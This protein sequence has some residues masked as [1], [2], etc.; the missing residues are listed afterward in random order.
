MAG[1][2]HQGELTQADMNDMLGYEND[3]G[4][5]DAYRT[6]DN[7]PQKSP[8][9]YA[10]EQPPNSSHTPVARQAS[11]ESM[12]ARMS[13]ASPA[14]MGFAY[15]TMKGAGGANAARRKT[16]IAGNKSRTSIKTFGGDRASDPPHPPPIYFVFVLV[17]SR[18]LVEC[19]ESPSTTLEVG[20]PQCLF[21]VR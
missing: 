12:A 7:T 21:S 15:M 6:M 10:N 4:V 1:K 8:T 19:A 14:A 5:D 16:L 20:A 11:T 3:V 13:H 9:K 18:T 17:S 2:T